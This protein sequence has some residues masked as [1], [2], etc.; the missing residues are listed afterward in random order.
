[1]EFREANRFRVHQLRAGAALAEIIHTVI[2]PCGLKQHAF[3][4][5]PGPKA[6]RIPPG[7]VPGCN[8]SLK[9]T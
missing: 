5:E 1:M 4:C 7:N 8:I 3:G 9:T 6:M 2:S